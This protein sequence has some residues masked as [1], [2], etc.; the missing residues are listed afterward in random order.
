[1]NG[2]QFDGIV[3]KVI[4][5]S[6]FQ[7]K[8]LQ[9]YLAERDNA[10]FQEAEA[11]ASSYSG[12]LASQNIPLDYAVTAYLAMCENMMKCQIEFMKTGRYTI[13]EL[14]KAYEEVYSND[15]KMKSYMI[16]LAISQFLW[17]THYAMYNFFCNK[18]AQYSSVTKSYL[19]IGP[20]HGLF[21][22]KAL[23]CLPKSSKTTVVDISATS[24]AI[25][26]SIMKY[27]GHDPASISYRTTNVLA[28]DTDER[29]DFVTMGEVLEHVN[30]PEKLLLKIHDMLQNNG[31]F[32][33]S[34]PVNAP[35]IDH[36][37]HF[38]KIEEIEQMLNS[39]GFDILD[40]RVLPTENLPM[41]EIVEKKIAINYCALLKKK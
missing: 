13:D 31:R 40:S 7:K 35:A 37:Y 15:A 32:F 22:K 2:K 36:V 24:I 26:M 28:F 33:I 9:Q 30:F 10:F 29:F 41:E 11:F 39:C 23:E 27:F 20:G 21:L 3:A 25:T 8:K 17:P 4:Q 1:M 19:E 16:G 14:G 5:K 12:Y 38:K 34:T 6:P 18:I